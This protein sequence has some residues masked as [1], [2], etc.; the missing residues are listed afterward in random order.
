L[1]QF[2]IIIWLINGRYKNPLS[3]QD[4]KL[5]FRLLKICRIASHFWN[6]E[7]GIFLFQLCQNF[8]VIFF[9]K[10]SN[11]M[12]KNSF[13]VNRFWYRRMPLGN[14][15]FLHG[16]YP[17]LQRREDQLAQDHPRRRFRLLQGRV[18]CRKWRHTSG[19]CPFRSIGYHGIYLPK[20]GQCFCKWF[21]KISSSGNFSWNQRLECVHRSSRN[22]TANIQRWFKTSDHW[23]D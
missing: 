13:Q 18:G 5:F 7:T 11:L 8:V 17:D 14:K 23:K 2:H 12:A 20:E 21:G 3:P 19:G 16:R 15:E 1:S 9:P 4:R 10:P 6:C 22:K